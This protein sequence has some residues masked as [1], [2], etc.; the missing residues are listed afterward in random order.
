MLLC[1]LLLVGDLASLNLGFSSVEMTK[2]GFQSMFTGVRSRARLVFSFMFTLVLARIANPRYLV[3]CIIRFMRNLFSC[4]F[5]LSSDLAG[6]KRLF[7][8]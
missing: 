1:P 4:F 2:Y 5:A 7:L 6:A 8:A 3:L